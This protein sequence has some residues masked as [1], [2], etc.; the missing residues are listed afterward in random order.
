MTSVVIDKSIG[1]LLLG[2][3]GATI[4]FAIECVQALHYFGQHFRD[5]R[6]IK[7]TRRLHRHL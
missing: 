7:L 2:S 1:A 3:Y 5:P 4:L 6:P